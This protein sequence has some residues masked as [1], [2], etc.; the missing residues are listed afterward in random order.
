MSS[1]IAV[2]DTRNA[3]ESFDPK[4]FHVL[5]PVLSVVAGNARSPYLAESVSIVAISP[6][7]ERGEVYTEFRYANAKEG[8]RALTSLGLKK[9]ADAAGIRF[10][11]TQVVDRERWVGRDGNRHARIHV[12]AGAAVRMLNGEWAVEFAEKEIDTE[13]WIEQGRDA[14]IRAAERQD[15]AVDERKLEADLRRDLLAFREHL[16]SH[17]ETR[18]RSRVIRR[19]LS[20]PQVFKVKDLE[21]PFAVPRLVFRPDLAGAEEIERIATIGDVSLHGTEAIAALYG[22]RGEHGSS[23]SVEVAEDVPAERPELGNGAPS[24]T[25]EPEEKPAKRKTSGRSRMGKARAT[26]KAK[27][28][29]AESGDTPPDPEPKQATLEEPAALPDEHLAEGPYA[30]KLLSELSRDEL[31]DV[32]EDEGSSAR[33]KGRARAWAERK[34]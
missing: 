2:A 18:A 8:K 21:R 10:L 25:M 28:P 1:E 22:R 29:A 9:I 26:G 6:D 19:I 20:L 4:Q 23:S 31:L 32:A 17:A 7:E 5:Q 3:L 30:G 33:R 12:R 15:R 16:L 27:D 14:K 13:D 34:Q 11:P 24:S